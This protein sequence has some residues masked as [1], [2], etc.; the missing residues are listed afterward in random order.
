MGLSTATALFRYPL[1]GMIDTHQLQLLQNLVR[2]AAR[3]ELMTRFESVGSDTKADGTLVT[4]ADLALQ[5]RLQDELATHWPNYALLGE[6]MRTA[7]QEGLLA[8]PGRGLWCLDPLDGTSNFA[9]GIP[10]FAVSLALLVDG[11]VQ[12]GVVYDPVREECFCALRGQGA[13]LNERSLITAARPSTLHEA[14]AIVDLKRLP[15]RLIMAIARRSP[16]RSQRSFGSV[17]L[18]WCWL[19][20]GRCHL[21]LHGGQKLW[22]Y[23]AGRLVLEE[24][25]GAGG[26]LADYSGDWL[27]E[28]S[29][30]PR[31][32]MAASHSAL[33]K[34]WRGWVSEGLSE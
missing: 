8:E 4:A 30:G 27:A 17:A 13:W 31:I 25:G 29:L 28:L 22:D 20:R 10:F 26:V 2:A 6:E 24:S 14:M 19:A 16:F 15:E 9:A 18:D 32:A 1:I 7:Q 34:Q 23:A 11:K 12:A 21:Y 3:D 5:Q 33:L